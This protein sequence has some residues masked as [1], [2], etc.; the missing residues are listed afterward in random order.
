MLSKEDRALIK[1]IRV[2]KGYDA[3]RIMTEFPGRNC[4]HRNGG[5]NAA[6]TG[7]Y[8][9]M[10]TFVQNNRPLIKHNYRLRLSFNALTLLAGRQEEHPA[11]KN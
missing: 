8:D 5:R 10:T 11:C 3:K 1:V 7:V 9:E 6:G 2:E 4:S